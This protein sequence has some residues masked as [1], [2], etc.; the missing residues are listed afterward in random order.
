MT[1]ELATRKIAVESQL[2]TLTALG[3]TISDASFINMIGNQ[4]AAHRIETGMNSANS[5]VFEQPGIEKKI[6]PNVNV[7]YHRDRE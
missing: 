5:E 4:L 6:K 2:A 1:G 7:T 3:H